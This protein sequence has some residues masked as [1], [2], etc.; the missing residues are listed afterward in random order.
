VPSEVH[1]QPRGYRLPSEDSDEKWTEFDTTLTFM[2][3]V[4]RL[5]CKKG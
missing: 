4:F 2:S 3:W 1:G 5:L